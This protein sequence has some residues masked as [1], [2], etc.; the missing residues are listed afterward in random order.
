MAG[1]SIV[2]AI[3]AVGAVMVWAGSPAMAANVTWVGASASTITPW[4]WSDG[5]NWDTLA[6]PSPGDDVTFGSAGSRAII[7]VPGGVTV[8][9]INFNRAASFT[10]SGTDTSYLVLNNGI[11]AASP[12]ASTRTYSISAW[13]NL[14]G[15][16]TWNV[17]N[18]NGPT[19]LRMYQDTDDTAPPYNPP[20]IVL[21]GNANIT[22][23]GGGDLA[24]YQSYQPAFYAWTGKMDVT[25]GQLNLASG[26]NRAGS[27]L[28]RANPLNIALGATVNYHM[29][30]SNS[31]QALI[32]G[33]ISGAGDLINTYSGST[34]T[35]RYG[36][37]Q[38]N[39]LGNASFSGRI[40]SDC[41]SVAGYDTD[42][43][44]KRLLNV[45]G[46]G[47][48][49]LSGDTSQMYGT[50]YFMGPHSTLTLAGAATLNQTYTND[51]VNH[52]SYSGAL[53]FNGGRLVL[54]NSAV[55]IDQ[56]I[57]GGFAG[58]YLDYNVPLNVVSGGGIT[59]IGNAA[60]TSQSIQNVLL[61]GGQTD[62][63]IVNPAAGGTGTELVFNDQ[64][65]TLATSTTLVNKPIYYAQGSDGPLSHLNINYSGATTGF[66]QA[67]DNPRLIISNT[68][69]NGGSGVSNGLFI[70]SGGDYSLPMTINGSDFAAW[71]NTGAG[72]PLVPY[73]YVADPAGRGVIIADGGALD[74][75]AANRNA[76]LDGSA[77]AIDGAYYNT[78]K[79][80]A[81]ITPGTLTLAG[82]LRL[83]SG[84]A[85]ILKTG[86]QNYL[87]TGGIVAGNGSRGVIFDVY[88]NGSLE[89]DSQIGSGSTSTFDNSIT[90][91]GP[92]L[93][94]ISGTN[95]NGLFSTRFT[96]INQGVLR[97]NVSPFSRVCLR[98]GVWEL[99]S[100]V[101]GLP[102]AY[103]GGAINWVGGSGSGSG[104]FSA[105]GGN[106]TVDLGLGGASDL[107]WASGSFV[108]DWGALMLSSPFAD[109]R[110]E[111]IDNIDLGGS[112]AIYNA[113]EIYVA[114]NA[115]PN[116]Y[117]RIS[118]VIKGGTGTGGTSTARIYTD[119]L[120][121]GGGALELTGLNTYQ[122]GTIVAEGSL[123]IG[124][125]APSGGPGALGDN[126]VGNPNAYVILGMRSG[127]SDAA[128]LTNG[129]FTVGRNITVS[130]GSTGSMTLGGNTAD[131]S[132]FSG[133]VGIGYGT[134]TAPRTLNL[135]AA[136]GG[137]VN[138]NGAFSKFP[139]F[140]GT[141]TLRIAGA[142]SIVLG[143]PAGLS[144]GGGNVDGLAF[145][146]PL[147]RTGTT[148]PVAG[149]DYQQLTVNGPVDLANGSLSM[150]IVRHKNMLG[151]VFT[152]IASNTPAVN[153]F[154]GVD[155]NGTGFADV[156]SGGAAGA[157][158]VTVSNISYPGDANR[159]GITDMSDYIIW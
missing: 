125:D 49:T 81:T 9:T 92:G 53:V 55:N 111:M 127:N 141:A 110:I 103:A 64:R 126:S 121:T 8:G 54:D 72:G 151:A 145:A 19:V 41:G 25:E 147:S 117:A 115:N 113:R 148:A 10:L 79:I 26:D 22:K 2:V 132:T 65:V 156:A 23:T 85:S 84:G 42:I 36:A 67:G 131:V 137:T 102:V 40:Y 116:A 60:G 119:L 11:N 21:T 63:T 86:D 124:A 135:T 12:D 99:T 106:R 68:N 43:T 48:Q 73:D 14:A 4:S 13:L 143:S 136:A 129:A 58:N 157:G 59:L 122:G 159:D 39:L 97:G 90:K 46:I 112:A 144:F 5:D 82:T 87:I 95:T 155:F 7:D 130:A 89:V 139:G 93:L 33:E 100:D 96:T 35:A 27:I 107:V 142:G 77:S 91:N 51:G 105:F 78:L 20:G 140:G 3:A 88:G 31:A 101:I 28:F 108:P 128:I 146:M 134:S 1:R 70:A 104:G 109:S 30:S 34:A 153:S 16:Q 18:T 47:N 6:M 52:P 120:K 56:R 61:S 75:T 123:L 44:L 150:S 15:A 50:T 71:A 114:G 152:I 32:V 118:G 133:N 154:A 17:D 74:S 80:S 149:V 66:G 83:T 38:L 24:F 69:I 158:W 98:G 57:P 94:I 45:R 29:T 62:I 138:F 76:R 37:M